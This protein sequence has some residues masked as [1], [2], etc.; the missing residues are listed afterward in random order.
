MAFVI[1]TQA[2]LYVSRIR[3]VQNIS[4]FDDFC[5]LLYSNGAMLY[6]KISLVKN[7]DFSYFD[8]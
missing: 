2:S 1:V 3:W 4:W 8:G 5:D 7:A 6:V